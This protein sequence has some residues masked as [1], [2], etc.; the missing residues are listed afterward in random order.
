MKG[1]DVFGKP[2]ITGQVGMD[3]T[4]GSKG[5]RGDQ[6]YPGMTNRLTLS[7]A[8]PKFFFTFF[9]LNCFGHNL[10]FWVFSNF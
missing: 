6:G 1:D 3:G 5:Q 9:C 7:W 4:R 10:T 8:N 2:G